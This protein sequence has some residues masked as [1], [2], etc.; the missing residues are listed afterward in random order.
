VEGINRGLSSGTAP[1][2]ASIDSGKK[3]QMAM[4]VG[5]RMEIRNEHLSI[6][7][8]RHHRFSAYAG[9]GVA[10]WL[11][12]GWEKRVVRPPWASESNGRKN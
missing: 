3:K 6:T 8:K 9:I 7:S 4:T 5:F 10:A 1:E 12:V 2:I 11:G